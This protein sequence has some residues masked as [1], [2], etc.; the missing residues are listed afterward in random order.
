MK[1]RLTKFLKLRRSLTTQIAKKWV[2]MGL[3]NLWLML[4]YVSD[5]QLIIYFIE[6][7]CKPTFCIQTY[8]V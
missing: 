5:S 1:V 6:K 8:E 3:H 4:S 7:K 2:Y